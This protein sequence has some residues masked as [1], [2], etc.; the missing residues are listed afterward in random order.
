M[1]ALQ[2]IERDMGRNPK[3]L[4]GVLRQNHRYRHLAV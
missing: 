4:M 3:P 2:Q 1:E